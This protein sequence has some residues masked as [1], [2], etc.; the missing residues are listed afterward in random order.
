[1][2]H[3]CFLHRI[4]PLQLVCREGYIDSARTLLSCGADVNERGGYDSTPLF[5]ACSNGHTDIVELLLQAGE[6][7]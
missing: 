2:L 6:G 4:T 1:M 3:I 7:F 5:Q